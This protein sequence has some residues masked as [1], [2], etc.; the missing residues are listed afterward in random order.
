MNIKLLHIFT[1][2]CSYCSKSKYQCSAAMTQAA[3]E[4]LDNKLGHFD[5][6]KNILHA[7]TS[8]GECS[9]Q[10]VVYHE[11]KLH[12]CRVFPSVCFVK[13]N[14]PKERSKIL[15]TEE[16]LKSLPYNS[17]NIFKRNILYRYIDQPN[18]S[19]CGGRYSMLDSF[20]FVE[21]L[22]CDSSCAFG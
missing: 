15:E 22:F 14:L 12:L 21:F 4:V 13:T 16:E 6:M 2:M 9:V 10:E 19:F 1:Y 17:T 8:K 3:K 11:P 20:C 5:T 18:H 7:Y